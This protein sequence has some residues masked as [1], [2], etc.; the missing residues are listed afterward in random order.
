M[1]H[2]PILLWHFLRLDTSLH[3]ALP[4]DPLL[5]QTLLS[6]I[7]KVTSTVDLMVNALH[8]PCPLRKGPSP[9]TTVLWAR[10]VDLLLVLITA[11]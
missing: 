6:H 10:Q 7:N 4:A 9:S 1:S 3:R 8:T 5:D 2:L 11:S